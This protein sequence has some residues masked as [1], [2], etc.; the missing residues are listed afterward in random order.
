M[1]SAICLLVVDGKSTEDQYVYAT[2]T[3]VRYK[4]NYDSLLFWGLMFVVN[5]YLKYFVND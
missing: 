5:F 1:I 2:N 3:V 4:C